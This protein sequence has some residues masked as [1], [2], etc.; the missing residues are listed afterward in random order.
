MIKTLNPS[1][2]ILIV[3]HVNHSHHSSDHLVSRS[4]VPFRNDRNIHLQN[5]KCLQFSLR[6]ATNSHLSFD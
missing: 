6:L 1:V 2:A 3:H 5:A 4:L